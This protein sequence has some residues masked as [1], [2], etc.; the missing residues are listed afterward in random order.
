MEKSSLDQTI[1]KRHLFLAIGCARYPYAKVKELFGDN[2]VL[3]MEELA[4]L[5]VPD[6]EKVQAIQ[7]GNFFS[8]PL[9]HLLAFRFAGSTYADLKETL[10]EVEIHLCEEALAEFQAVLIGAQS[11][12]SFYVTTDKI[13]NYL[14]K[15]YYDQPVAENFKRM[16]AL[17]IMICLR[18][19]SAKTALVETSSIQRDVFGDE[20]GTQQLNEMLTISRNHYLERPF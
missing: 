20:R 3:N 14:Y 8:S 15:T 5:P 16:A 4:K 17:E 10:N 7:E 9:A 19:D 12:Q 18:R 2:Q 13:K 1:D 11:W 6:D